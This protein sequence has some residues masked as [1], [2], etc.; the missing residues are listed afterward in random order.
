MSTVRCAESVNMLAQAPD[1]RAEVLTALTVRPV[2]L[3][4]PRVV[5][6]ADTG[7]RQALK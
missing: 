7:K 4:N 5:V 6:R 3:P 2:T 1:P